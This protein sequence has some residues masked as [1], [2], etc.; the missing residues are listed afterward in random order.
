MDEEYLALSGE[1]DNFKRVRDQSRKYRKKLDEL[2]NMGGLDNEYNI[3][4]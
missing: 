4:N 1:V 2:V 3:Q